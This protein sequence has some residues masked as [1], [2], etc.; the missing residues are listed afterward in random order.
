MEKVIVN[1]LE[2]V[3]DEP[4]NAL[5]AVTCVLF[6]SAMMASLPAPG[7]AMMALLPAPGGVAGN[8]SARCCTVMA[9]RVIAQGRLRSPFM[10]D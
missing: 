3:G 5:V 10:I 1:Y 6:V 4:L 8:A 9:L 2:Y 7:W